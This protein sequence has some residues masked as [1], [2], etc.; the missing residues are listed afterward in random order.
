MSY[1]T[2]NTTNNDIIK[3]DVVQTI[4]ERDIV[5][6]T[7][8]NHYNSN[9]ITSNNSNNN[10]INV[11][12]ATQNYLITTTHQLTPTLISS[13][14]TGTMSSTPTSVMT[15]SSTSI[16]ANNGNL[17]ENNSLEYHQIINSNFN[18]MNLNSNNSNN[19]NNANYYNHHN[20]RNYVQPSSETYL[21]STNINYEYDANNGIKHYMPSN[22][23][24]MVS[25]IV[26]IVFL[27]FNYQVLLLIRHFSFEF[28][29]A[30]I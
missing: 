19:N 3:N 17:I 26:I 11:N 30:T 20:Y 1:R 13:H 7:L 23:N 8:P 24:A 10:S 2:N 27:I 29:L 4:P 9:T 5:L 22:V 21:Q 18:K 14:I 16:P 28:H 15:A 25:A 12:K 6:C